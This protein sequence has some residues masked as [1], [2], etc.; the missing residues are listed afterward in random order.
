MFQTL[1]RRNQTHQLQLRGVQPVRQIVE[2][3]GYPLAPLG[4]FAKPF[5][6]F[7]ITESLQIDHQECGLLA[8]VVVQLARNA[9]A[10]DF[11]RR[12]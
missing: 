8:H 2:A 7:A 4:D 6:A 11:L 9:R 12:Q 10:L 5:A 1:K 3:L